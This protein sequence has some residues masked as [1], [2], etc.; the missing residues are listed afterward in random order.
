MKQLGS[1][2]SDG[3]SL[4]EL[5]AARMESM[6]AQ[7]VTAFTLRRTMLLLLRAFWSISAVSPFIP[8][9]ADSQR[10]TKL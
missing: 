7:G 2:R 1:W 5:F 4:R 10:A 6:A 8:S 9:D 3:L